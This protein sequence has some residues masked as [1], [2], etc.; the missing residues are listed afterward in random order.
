MTYLCSRI[1]ILFFFNK[2]V[3]ANFMFYFTIAAVYLAPKSFSWY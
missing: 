1:S 2:T 3:S